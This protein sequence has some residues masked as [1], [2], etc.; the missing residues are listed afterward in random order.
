MGLGTGDTTVRE[1]RFPVRMSRGERLSAFREYWCRYLAEDP[2][3]GTD[4]DC[5]VLKAIEEIKDKFPE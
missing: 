2:Q 3:D 5:A 1:Q 4:L